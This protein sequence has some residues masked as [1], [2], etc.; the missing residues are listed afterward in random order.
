MVG[1]SQQGVY[2]LGGHE[3]GCVCGGEGATLASWSP[4]ARRRMREWLCTCVIA[5]LVEECNMYVQKKLKPDGLLI[6]LSVAESL[7][8][9]L[10]QESRDLNCRDVRGTCRVLE[11]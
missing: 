1:Q 8:E 3:E 7:G 9:V 2:N 5:E 11:L 6:V 4:L 10:P